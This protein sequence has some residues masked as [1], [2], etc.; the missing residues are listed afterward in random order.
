MSFRQPVRPLDKNSN[1][2]KVPRELLV[3]N[4]TGDMS[5][6][7]DAGSEVPVNTFTVQSSGT[8]QAISA[9]TVNGRTINVVKDVTVPDVS[10]YVRISDEDTP[11]ETEEADALPSYMADYLALDGGQMTGILYAQSNTN[12]TT[13]QVRNIYLSTSEPSS[14]QGQNGDIWLIYEE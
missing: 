5:V 7:N 8:G 14:S 13:G 3:D 9:V 2:T 4:S 11:V 12:Y 1:E 10:M 6:I